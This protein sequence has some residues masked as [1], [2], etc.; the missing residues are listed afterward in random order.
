MSHDFRSVRALL[1]NPDSHSRELLTNAL[2]NFGC[3]QMVTA[4][5]GGE[6]EHYLK[7][8][9]IDLLV[10]DA[11]QGLNDACD[12]VQDMRRRPTADNTF[13]IS[14]ILTSP[15]DPRYAAH[16]MDSGADAILLKPLQTNVVAERLVSLI[17]NRKS[18]V[19][20]SDYV[21]PERR[22][23][24]M[25]P[26]TES[27][28]RV[29]VPNPLREMA[30]SSMSRDELRRGIRMG[31][32]TVNEHRIERQAARLSWLVD[33]IREAFSHN[34][35]ASEAA[36]RILELRDAAAELRLRVEGGG[37]DHVSHLATTMIDICCGLGRALE[38]PDR[39]WLAVMPQLAASIAAAFLRERDAIRATRSA[40]ATPMGRPRQE[41][42]RIMRS[43]H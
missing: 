20:T 28:P 9:M 8:D 41:V 30:M 24:G 37:Y 19:V 4:A 11:D 36:S 39:R 1:R 10:V 31:W 35:P 26:G 43:Y 33:R 29:A 12:L 2:A 23:E 13:A 5:H 7:S 25:R 16:L 21:G 38:S 18:F 3:R 14:I 22:G 32:E 6:V 17:S 40:A 34:P 27:A 15:P 42:P